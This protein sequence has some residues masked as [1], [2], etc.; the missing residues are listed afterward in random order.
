MKNYHF[1]KR[2]YQT[3]VLCSISL[4]NQHHSHPDRFR[5]HGYKLCFVNSS[6]TI[7]NNIARIN[8]QGRLSKE[9][10]KKQVEAIMFL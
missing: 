9:R 3:Y 2:L 7:L 6:H 10:E 5:Y 1:K 4:Y 8:H